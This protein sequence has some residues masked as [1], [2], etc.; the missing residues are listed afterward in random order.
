MEA[1]SLDQLL[2]ARVDLLRARMAFASN[3]GS[4]APELLLVA[5]GR[6]EMLDPPLARDTYLEAL[7]AA[8]FAGRLTSGVGLSGSAISSRTSS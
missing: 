1:A 2:R 3:R 5:A 8:M 6:L 7:S 4:A